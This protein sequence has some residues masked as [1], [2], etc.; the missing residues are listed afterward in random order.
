MMELII[1]PQVFKTVSVDDDYTR[2]FGNFLYNF[3]MYDA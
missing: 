3:E 2:L 1:L